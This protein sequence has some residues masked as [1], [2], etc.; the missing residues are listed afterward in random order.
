MLDPSTGDVSLRLCLTGL[1]N[2]WLPSDK[3]HAVGQASS[4]QEGTWVSVG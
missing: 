4:G 2:C 1:D 3:E